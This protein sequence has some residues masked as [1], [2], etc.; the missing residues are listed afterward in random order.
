[1]AVSAVSTD[2]KPHSVSIYIDVTAEWYS[3]DDTQI[4]NW[5]FV[6]GQTTVYHQAQIN[7]QSAFTEFNDHIQRQSQL[8]RSETREL[9]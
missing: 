5:S 6:Q 2:G 8:W 7:N 4:V 3:G 9:D 1:M